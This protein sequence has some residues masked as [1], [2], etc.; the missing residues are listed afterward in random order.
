MRSVSCCPVVSCTPDHLRAAAGGARRCCWHGALSGTHLLLA[1]DPRQKRLP[2]R[3]RA[4]AWRRMSAWAGGLAPCTRQ[5]WL[6][7]QFCSKLRSRA[8]C[9]WWQRCAPAGARR[10]GMGPPGGA[11]RHA[12]AHARHVR[13]GAA[14]PG[15]PR[16]RAQGFICSSEWPAAAQPLPARRPPPWL[17]SPHPA[18]RQ[19]VAASAHGQGG[20]AAALLQEQAVGLL[21]AARKQ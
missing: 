3:L 8:F 4:L 2:S 7:G 17:A 18:R 1:R 19:A 5:H 13:R 21:D 10:C 15:V 9:T 16:G 20:S 11:G 6:C 12:A 14:A